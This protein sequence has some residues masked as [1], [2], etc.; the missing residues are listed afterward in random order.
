ML[1][2]K[3]GQISL[4]CR[5][6]KIIKGP[7]ISFQSPAL[8]QKHGR[9]VCDTAHQYLTKFHFDSIYDSKEISVSVTSLC[10]NSYDP[11]Q[12]LRSVDLTKAQ[13]PRYLENET[14]FLQI[15]EKSL[16]THQGLLCSKKSFAAEVIFNQFW[17]K[18]N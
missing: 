3:N 6:N 5:F 18:L 8:S 2:I 17:I 9:N 13:R 1:T 16:I 4:Y 10:T 15:K 14:F 12:I 11:S 7:E